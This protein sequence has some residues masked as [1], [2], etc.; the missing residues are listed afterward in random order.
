MDS[1]KTLSFEFPVSSRIASTSGGGHDP[2]LEGR[3]RVEGRALVG[4]AHPEVWRHYRI[5]HGTQC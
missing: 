5:L 3:D 4:Q 1:R 2:V